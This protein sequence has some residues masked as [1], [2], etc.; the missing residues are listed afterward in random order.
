MARRVVWR[1]LHVAIRTDLRNRSLSREELLSMTI[2]T[3]CV[4][5]KVG[6]ACVAFESNLVTRIAR[7]L[8]F[9]H[10]SGVRKV[11]ARLH[12]RETDHDKC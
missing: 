7:E 1:R 11:R 4:F 12:E 2:Q 6:D 8:F 9:T 3:R 5:R 10:M